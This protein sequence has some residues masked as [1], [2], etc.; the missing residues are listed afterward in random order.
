MVAPNQGITCR[1]LFCVIFNLTMRCE[2]MWTEVNS[3]CA[4][5][6]F[7]LWFILRAAAPLQFST[8]LVPFLS[9]NMTHWKVRSRHVIALVGRAGITCMLTLESGGL[10]AKKLACPL[11][12]F[13]FIDGAVFAFLSI[14]NLH[15]TLVSTEGKGILWQQSLPNSFHWSFLSLLSFLILLINT[16]FVILNLL[17]KFI[18]SCH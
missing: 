14:V 15:L 13:S 2:Y 3:F 10:G 5:I 11:E 16:N 17:L 7:I 8:E 12:E 6:W 1:L 4:F 9:W 18:Y